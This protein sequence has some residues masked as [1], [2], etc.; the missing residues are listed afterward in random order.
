M[1]YA[2]FLKQQVSAIVEQYFAPYNLA[3]I[4][5]PGH[6][7]LMRRQGMEGGQVVALASFPADE[8]VIWRDDK[9]R[10]ELWSKPYE[11]TLDPNDAYAR[12]WAAFTRSVARC[13]PEPHLNGRELQVDH[14][15]PE[16]AGTRSGLV[17]VRLMP[18]DARPNRTVGSTIEKAAAGPKPGSFGR[19]RHA[20]PFTLAKVSG[21][22]LSFAKRHN[23]TQVAR[24][25]WDHIKA[26]GY[27]V[28]TGGLA[29]FD[30]NLT[31]GTLDWFR[32]E[33]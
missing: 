2:S 22:Q 16:T 11:K 18:V 20:T 25:L 15:Y 14:L 10:T 13:E 5:V 19:P 26:C 33:R 27:P 8:A 32:G 3:W 21:F 29:G 28:P 12:A 9:G 31:A 4:G 7:W 23:S 30:V 1:D 24:A 6:D 17:L